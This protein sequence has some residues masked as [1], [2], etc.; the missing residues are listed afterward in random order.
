MEINHRE[1]WTQALVS[2]ATAGRNLKAVEA[3]AELANNF[4]KVRMA[5]EYIST[6]HRTYYY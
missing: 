2:T 6:I 4:H 3:C 1:L 5:S